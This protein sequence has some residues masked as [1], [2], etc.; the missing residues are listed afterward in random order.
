MPIDDPAPLT[1]RHPLE[2]PD[3]APSVL[4]HTDGGCTPNPG[5]GGWGAILWT[6][7]HELEIGGGCAD[8]TNNRM[9]ITA[10]LQAL[11]VLNT[12]CNV[13][14]VTDS[15]YLHNGI[16]DWITRWSQNLWRRKKT[17]IQNS[18]LWEALAR[19]TLRHRTSWAWT[20][21]HVGHEANERCDEIATLMTGRDDSP[22]EPVSHR[23]RTRRRSAPPAPEK[24]TLTAPIWLPAR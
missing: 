17:P 5:P 6:P 7:G 12:P 19:A 9:E 4:V 3:D 18:D 15:S 13:T 2:L 22:D 11:L 1:E 20:R 14:I 21:A 8:T 16:T 24:R 23:V 10:A